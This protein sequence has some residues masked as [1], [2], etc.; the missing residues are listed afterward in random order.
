MPRLR[1][2]R[3]VRPGAI[4]GIAAPGGPVDADLLDE[5]RS[6]LESGLSDRQRQEIVRLLV[7]RINI[8]TTVDEDG[9]KEAKAT[10]MYNFPAL[11]RTHTDTRAGLDYT[12]VQR[13]VQLPPGGRWPRK[14]AAA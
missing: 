8:T 12:N 9:N 3:A 7:G 13:V 1:K 5:L 4:I 10:I 2:P 14:A 11:V 6:R